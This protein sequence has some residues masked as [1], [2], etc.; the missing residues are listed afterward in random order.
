MPTAA[1]QAMRAFVQA[2]NACEEAH[3]A[4]MHTLA[5]LA[6]DTTNADAIAAHDHAVREHALSRTKLDRARAYALAMAC[7]C[8]SCAS[9]RRLHAT[10]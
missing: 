2:R 5:Q 10:G 4:E 3:L 9:A 7:E 8:S 6:V 1:D